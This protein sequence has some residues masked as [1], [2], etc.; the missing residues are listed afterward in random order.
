MLSQAL[1]SYPQYPALRAE[2]WCSSIHRS[3]RHTSN[4]LRFFAVSARQNAVRHRIM[5]GWELKTK[6]FFLPEI[7][8]SVHHSD[9]DIPPDKE[10]HH[11]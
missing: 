10:P 2:Y 1:R 9:T 5:P 3:N 7:Q 11:L 6:P 4:P 8:G